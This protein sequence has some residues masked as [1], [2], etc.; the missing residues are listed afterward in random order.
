[1]VRTMMKT[2][3]SMDTSANTAP[4]T[5][6]ARSGAVEKLVMPSTARFMSFA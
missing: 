6:D 4:S 1:M 2:P 3:Y 5:V